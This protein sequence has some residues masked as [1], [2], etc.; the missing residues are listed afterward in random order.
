MERTQKVYGR[1]DGRLDIK[2][3]GW[4]DGQRA[5]H[6]MT[7]LRRAYKNHKSISEYLISEYIKRERV[8]KK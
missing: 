1:T 5:R 8:E 3:D 7:H 2:T 6:N 4:M